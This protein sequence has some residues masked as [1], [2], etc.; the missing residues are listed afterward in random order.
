VSA[1][2]LVVD[3]SVLL[4]S[5]LGTDQRGAAAREAITG[6][7]ITGPEH[8]AVET[9]HGI[10][11]LALGKVVTRQAAS[12]AV[13]RLSVLPIDTVAS[14][15]LLARMWELRENVSGYDAAYVAAAEHLGLEL[16]TRDAGIHRAPGLHCRLRWP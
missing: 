11:G 6:H 15:S 3:A 10:R 7:L 4:D 12:R 8:L 5:L 14:A 2:S 13:Q 9:F 1:P 16:L